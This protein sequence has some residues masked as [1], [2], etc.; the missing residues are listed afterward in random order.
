MLPLEKMAKDGKLKPLR[1]AAKECLSDE[2]LR[3]WRGQED[4]EMAADEEEDEEVEW[5]GFAD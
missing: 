3:A 5:G 4:E 2:R 1:S